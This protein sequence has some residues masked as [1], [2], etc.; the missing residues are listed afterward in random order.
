M[1]ADPGEVLPEELSDFE[2]VDT[3]V[4]HLLRSL[5]EA[6]LFLEAFEEAKRQPFYDK[7]QL[8]IQS[9]RN[10][11]SLEKKATGEVPLGVLRLADEGR[12]PDEFAE[13]LIRECE[14]SARAVQRKHQWMQHL[15]NSLDSLV[16]VNFPDDP[17]RRE[18][19]TEAESREVEMTDAAS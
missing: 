4:C 15:K 9:F 8:I 6:M 1:A 7:L 16:D 14:K 12:N 5:N 10:I 11:Q 17:L 3:E 13:F 19:E 2:V 18:T